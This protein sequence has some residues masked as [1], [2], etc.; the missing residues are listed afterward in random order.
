MALAL[1]LAIWLA[2]PRAG[3][4]LTSGATA[5]DIAGGNWINSKPLT[6]MSLKG[7]VVHVEFWTYG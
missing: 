7:R 2:W 4:A 6:L 5:P 3:T 1:A